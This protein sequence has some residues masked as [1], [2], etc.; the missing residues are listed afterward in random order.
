MA[1]GKFKTAARNDSVR[2]V[3]HPAQ[4]AN[5]R[6]PTERQLRRNTDLDYS[7]PVA[8]GDSDS[9]IGLEIPPTRATGDVDVEMEGDRDVPAPS[10]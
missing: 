6:S 10:S 5:G 3:W 2:H 1:Y 9:G 4:G 8:G 7:A